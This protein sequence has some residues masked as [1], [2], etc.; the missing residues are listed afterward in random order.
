MHTLK[1][2][3][4]VVGGGAC[5]VRNITHWAEG[6]D[7]LAQWPGLETTAASGQNSVHGVE[8]SVQIRRQQVRYNSFMLEV[9]A[10]RM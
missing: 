2:G 10:Q 5:L 9:Q 6:S 1:L 4:Q 7:V 3:T 8:I